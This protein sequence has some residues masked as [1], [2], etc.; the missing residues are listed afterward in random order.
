MTMKE[1]I[2]ITDYANLITKTLPKGILLNTSA[3][4]F[5]S[6]VIGWGHIT[7]GGRRGGNSIL[8]RYKICL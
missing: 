5:N 6:I 8:L 3:D 2:D 4:K 7:Q 1:Q